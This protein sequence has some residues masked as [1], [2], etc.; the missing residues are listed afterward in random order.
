[1]QEILKPKEV[2]KMLN[3]TVNTLQR[4]DREKK[5]I[6][7]RNPISNRRYYTQEQISILLNKGK[8]TK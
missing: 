3:V 4:W 1:M 5:L 6:A 7:Y 8:C 2:A